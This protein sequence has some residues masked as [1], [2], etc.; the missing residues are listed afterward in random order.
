MRESPSDVWIIQR[1]IGGVTC[2]RNITV[3]NEAAL[4]PRRLRL[5]IS[6]SPPRRVANG[7]SKL[8]DSHNRA[9][10]FVGHDSIVWTPNADQILGRKSKNS[11]VRGFR[12]FPTLSHLSK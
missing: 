9:R 3:F 8:A 1:A 4:I 7:S 10:Y 2:H 5:P 11:C 12:T 6:R